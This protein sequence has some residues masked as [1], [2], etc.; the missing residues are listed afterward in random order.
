MR[1]APVRLWLVGWLVMLPASSAFGFGGVTHYTVAHHTAQALGEPDP[2]LLEAFLGAALQ[3]DLLNGPA[4]PWQ[5]HHAGE[6][7]EIM[8]ELAETPTQAALAYGY[9]C[10]VMA[11][12]AGHG[13]CIPDGIEHQ[14]VEMSIDILLVHSPDPVESAV[15]RETVLAC[16]RQLLHDALS[17]RNER[18]GHPF[19]E[20]SLQQVEV[21]AA[22]F[23]GATALLAGL[24]ADP[25]WL[26]FAEETAV[27]CWREECFNDAVT[28]C[29]D[30]IQSHPTDEALDGGGWLP[31]ARPSSEPAGTTADY[32][33]PFESPDTDGDG[34]PDCGTRDN[35]P[36]HWNPDQTDEDED[37]WGAAC[38]CDDANASVNPGRTEVPGNGWDD[39]CDPSTPDQVAWQVA[40]PA[41]AAERG[42]GAA[43]VPTALDGAKGLPVSF[44][45]AWIFLGA[46]W[47]RTT[48]TRGW[49]RRHRRPAP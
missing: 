48:G 16:D 3:P 39:D 42:G 8:L 17:L 28:G 32:T 21:M 47:R 12:E 11:D 1:L 45:L 46:M 29:I 5:M 41:E 24:Y 26:P 10:H 13:H 44:L 36:E 35:C 40:S 19:P 27:P 38:D 15:A 2:I 33:Y 18:L 4:Y 9:A 14:L 37:G 6:L 34:V 31:G 49:P 20:V 22:A 30:W 25:A 23:E 7:A 43:G